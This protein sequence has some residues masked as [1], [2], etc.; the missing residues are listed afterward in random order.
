MSWTG[1][2]VRTPAREKRWH[3]FLP[4]CNAREIERALSEL[5]SHPNEFSLL[6]NLVCD[7]V[8][9][10]WLWEHNDQ[11]QRRAG[12]FYLRISG[13]DSAWWKSGRVLKAYLLSILLFYTSHDHLSRGSTTM[14]GLSLLPHQ[15]ASRK[16][17][18]SLAYS[19]VW[20]R[21]FISWGCLF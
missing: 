10:L 21:Q 8:C 14:I 15:Y 13:P 11:Q 1:E 9:F 20:Y 18:P 5:P 19:P 17:P 2:T 12:L 7:L 6:F 4:E 3:Y 16:Y